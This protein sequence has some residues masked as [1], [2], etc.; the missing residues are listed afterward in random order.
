MDEIHALN[1]LKGR[2]AASNA[3]GRFEREKRISVD[4]GW[5]HE[6]GEED[7]PPL[8]TS[9]TLDKS[10]TIIARN[11]SPDVP[12]DRSINPYR[13]CEHGCV[14]CFARP[15]HAFLGLSPGLDFET[16]LFAKPDAA[17]LLARALRKPGY[18]CR[19]MAL[20]TN[21]DP[22]QPIDR[23]M[24]IT[25]AV[26][27]VLEAFG[28][29]VGIVTKSA[30]ILRDADI[31]ARMAERRLA[32]AFVSLTT[33]DSGLARKMEPRAPTPGRRLEAISGLA[34]AGVP[35][36]VMTAPMIPGLNDHELEDLLTAAVGAGATSAGFVLLRLPLEIEDL[37]SEWLSVHAPA[38]AQRV[39]NLMREARGGKLYDSTFGERMKGRGPYAKLIQQRFDRASARLGFKRDAFALDT[40]LFRPPPA[41]GD[42]LS[43][44]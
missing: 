28:H 16:R 11:S 13:G 41:P 44:L 3:T 33:L 25:R 2:G 8:R 19:V 43:L 39:L 38:R 29:P 7:L 10:R 27:E 6:E 9:V 20:G 37:F 22:Y 26:L 17:D 35:V 5:R 15:T 12:F 30:L 24:K 36:G 40:S 23:R 42:Q 14:Y 31:L 34:E 4:D 18:R 32:R 21:T 1:P